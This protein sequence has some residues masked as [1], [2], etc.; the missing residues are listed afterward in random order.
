LSPRE[1]KIHLVID[2]LETGGDK[3][4]A[5]KELRNALSQRYERDTKPERSDKLTI[6]KSKAK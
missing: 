3:D 1:K 6:R 4:K 5:I 2:D